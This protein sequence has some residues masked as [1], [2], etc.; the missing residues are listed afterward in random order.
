MSLTVVPLISLRRL[1]FR[2]IVIDYGTGCTGLF[3]IERSGKILITLSAR[4]AITGAE[5][6]LTFDNYYVNGAKV[7]GTFSIENLGPNNNQNVVFGVSLAGGKITFPDSKVITREFTRQR[8]Y[9]AGYGTW[10]PWDDR[11][12][13]TGMSAGT[14]PTERHLL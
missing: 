11:C 5:R 6:V 7:E 14:N 3:D 8:E 2:N 12:L 13:I 4:G 1:V 9:I 10:N